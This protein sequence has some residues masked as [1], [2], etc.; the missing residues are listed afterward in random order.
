M[1]SKPFV[2]QRAAFLPARGAVQRRGHLQIRAALS[3]QAKEEQVA[4]LEA[5]F[6]QSSVVVGLKY[7]GLS[8]K[9][10]QEFRRMLPKD[11]TLLVVKNT[12]LK[13]AAERVEGWG[14]LKAAA[15]GDNAWLFMGEE[16]I[17]ESVKAYV[18][19]EAKAKEALPKEEREASTLLGVSGGVMDTKLLSALEVRKL[20]D[21]PTKQELIATIARLINQLPTKVARGINQVPT[22]LAYGVKALADGQDDKSALVGDVFPKPEAA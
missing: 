13:L 6:A 3:R 12:L 4:R 9:Q 16:S 15:K 22:K 19:A 11:T 8:V 20:K 1:A 18:A 17:A 7:Q 5:L 10:L 21:L 2:A 14:E